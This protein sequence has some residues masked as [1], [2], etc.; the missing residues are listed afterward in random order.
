MKRGGPL[1]RKPMK[2]GTK[3]GNPHGRPKAIFD[4]K[5]A[6]EMKA[7]GVSTH[8]ISKSLGVSQSVVWKELR[9]VST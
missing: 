2:P 8:A 9:R 6:E 3:P 4:R 1:Q 5:I 7:A